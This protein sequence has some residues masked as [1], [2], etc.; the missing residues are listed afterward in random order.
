MIDIFYNIKIKNESERRKSTAGASGNKLHPI[1][2]KESKEVIEAKPL[3]EIANRT[4][5]FK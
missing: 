5:H 3:F 2:E 1:D 4:M